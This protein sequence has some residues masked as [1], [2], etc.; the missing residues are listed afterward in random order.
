MEKI[1]KNAGIEAFLWKSIENF[2]SMCY[3]W[4]H[5]NREKEQ[6]GGEND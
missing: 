5:N 2:I 4:K 6:K 3:N 1:K